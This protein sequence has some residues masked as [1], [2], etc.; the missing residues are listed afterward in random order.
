VTGTPRYASWEYVAALSAVPGLSRA[1]HLCGTHVDDLLQ[2]DGSLVTKLTTEF[3]FRRVQI[4]PTAVNGV[5]VSLMTPDGAAR[6]R[7]TMQS[8][9]QVEFIIQK[10]EETKALWEHLVDNPPPNLSLLVDES[11]GTGAE[12]KGAWP[13]P[14]AEIPTGYAGGIGP[15]NVLEVLRTLLSLNC[16]G[17]KGIWIDM[18]SRLR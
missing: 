11:C 17:S 3:G 9:G 10:N 15:H 6:V 12:M 1:A 16:D 13:L 4:N 18:E 8:L 7:E 2:G 14:D 5:D